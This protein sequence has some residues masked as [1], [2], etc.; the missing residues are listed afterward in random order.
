MYHYPGMTK[1]M[2]G[3]G[4]SLTK[5]TFILH[6]EAGAFTD[7]EIVVMLGE[8]G[9]GK[10]TFIRMMAGLLKSDE[11]SKAEADGDMDLALSLGVPQLNVR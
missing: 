9:T 11:Q 6:V 2:T 10:T 3:A 1:T 5:Q 7:S 4:D 8:N